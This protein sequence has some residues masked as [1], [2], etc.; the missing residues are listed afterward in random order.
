MAAIA[1]APSKSF[2]ELRGALPPA[3]AALSAVLEQVTPDRLPARM[4]HRMYGSAP[5]ASYVSR[6]IIGHKRRH[7]AQLRTSFDYLAGGRMCLDGFV[8][9]PRPFAERYRRD[10]LWQGR[11]LGELFDHWAARSCERAAVAGIDVDG[12]AQH[13]S[14]AALQQRANNLAAHLHQRGI[15]LGSRVV[16]QLPNVPGFVTLLLA[17]FKVG[18]VPV[19]ALPQHGAHEIGYLLDHSGASAYAVA[20]IFRGDDCVARARVLSA[21]RPAL[22]HILVSGE[23]GT[24]DVIALDR[25]ETTPAPSAVIRDRLRATSR[26][27]SFRGERRRAEAHPEDAR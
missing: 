7:V 18:A 25:L 1:A 24:D 2:G 12:V 4:N 5:L 8:P 22:Q 16:V 3:F 21:S 19:L 26:C 14:Y 20:R 23:P 11:T 17:L 27:F 6:D 10:G 9:V 15:A 13:L